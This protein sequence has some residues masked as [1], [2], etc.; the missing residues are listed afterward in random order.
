MCPNTCKYIPIPLEFLQ[1]KCLSTPC[2]HLNYT[3][4]MCMSAPVWQQSWIVF[5]SGLCVCL[6]FL[7]AWRVSGPSQ[8]HHSQKKLEVTPK[9]IRLI[10]I[11]VF[12]YHIV[13]YCIVLCIISC[14][15]VRHHA[16][17]KT[18][19]FGVDRYYR[20]HTHPV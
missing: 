19:P 3:R 2:F 5:N 13:L 9:H 11:W 7:R 8:L 1:E 4:C 16:T 6:H 18:Q 15:L 10:T 17:L 20:T 12:N 14:S